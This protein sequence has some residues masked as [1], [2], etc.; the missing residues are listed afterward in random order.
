M[1]LAAQKFVSDLANDA[2]QHCKM[3]GAGQQVS[4]SGGGKKAGSSKDR[5]Y[6][7]TLEDLSLALADQ[8]ITL[9]KPPYY[10]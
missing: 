10:L 2:L 4:G 3:R 7:L 6:V 1:S 9:K 8:G 5:R